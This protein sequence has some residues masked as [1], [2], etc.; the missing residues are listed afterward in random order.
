MQLVESR[1]LSKRPVRLVEFAG[2]LRGFGFPID[3]CV[4]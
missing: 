1:G 4:G 2:L 3:D